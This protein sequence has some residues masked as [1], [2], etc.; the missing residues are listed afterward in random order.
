MRQCVM[1]FPLLV[2]VEAC[3]AKK[4]RLTH[5]QKNSEFAVYAHMFLATSKKAN[6]EHMMT[7]NCVF[8]FCRRRI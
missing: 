2:V 8:G 4:L 7:L 5:F 1:G 6:V 3:L